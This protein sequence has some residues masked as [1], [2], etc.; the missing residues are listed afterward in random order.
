[1]GPTDLN[2]LFVFCFG[3]FC[4]SDRNWLPLLRM[5]LTELTR[6]PNYKV[7]LLEPCWKITLWRAG[8]F[9]C[10]LFCILYVAHCLI[11]LS[12]L[13]LSNIFYKNSQASQPYTVFAFWLGFELWASTSAKPQVIVFKSG[14]LSCFSFILSCWSVYCVNR[15]WA[16]AQNK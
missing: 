8:V 13:Q 15:F 7:R 16:I 12:K 5:A 9:V 3:S 2:S 1:M 14:W 10:L 11:D 4:F 6:S